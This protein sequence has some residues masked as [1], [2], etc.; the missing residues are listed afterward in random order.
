MYRQLDSDKIVLTSEKLCRRVSARFPDSGL[1]RVAAELHQVAQQ[2]A[3][4]SAWLAK[5]NL[6]VRTGVILCIGLIGLAVLG[7]LVSV[8]LDLAFRSIAEFV[9]AIESTINDIVFIAVAIFFLLGWETRLKRGRA[10]KAIHELRSLAHVIDMHQLTKDPEMFALPASATAYSPV[11]TLTAFELSRYLDYCT[12]MLSI[13]SKI[14]A[15]Y[16]QRFDDHVTVA[17]VNDIEDL[18]TGLARKIW[19]KLM[20]LDRFIGSS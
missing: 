8:D 6:P 17:A 3:A 11:R 14:A 18:T 19:Q 5:P 2:A 9:Q 7:T 12:E 13:I 20:I 16:I 15:V 4:T 10:L 1:G